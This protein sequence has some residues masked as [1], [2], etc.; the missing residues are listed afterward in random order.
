[1]P[2]Q[3]RT[4]S[5]TNVYHAIFRGVNKQQ[6]FEDDEDYIRLLNVFRRQTLPDIDAQGQTFQS[7]CH[8][9]AYSL[10]GNYVH[11]LLKEG[12]SQVSQ[13]FDTP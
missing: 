10:M 2:R 12:S 11:L 6:V 8:V 7:R 5:A 9:Y 3:A 13:A 1:M 4:I